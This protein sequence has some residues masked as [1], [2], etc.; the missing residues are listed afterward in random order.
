MIVFY[1]Y[2]INS[3][4]PIKIEQTTTNFQDKGQVTLG[5]FNS[6]ISWLQNNL[7]ISFNEANSIINKMN[8]LNYYKTSLNN[9]GMIAHSSASK[10]NAQRNNILIKINK[11]GQNLI[12]RSFIISTQCIV[13][14][15]GEDEQKM[16]ALYNYMKQIGNP[17]WFIQ[18][19]MQ[20]IYNSQKWP[21]LAGWWRPLNSQELNQVYDTINNNA[22]PTLNNAIINL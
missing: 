9:F 7:F 5:D 21:T 22:A 4:L 20:K 13:E 17:E 18:Q 3:L 11:N 1:L 14:S 8:Y 19:Q 2:F 6:A 10:R 16:N 12:I 15:I